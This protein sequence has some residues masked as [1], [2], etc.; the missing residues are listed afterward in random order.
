MT[1]RLNKQDLAATLVSTGSF[2]TKKAA[3]IAIEAVTDAIRGIVVAGNA[4]AIPDFGKFEAYTRE[5][6]KVKPKFIP[7]GSFKADMVGA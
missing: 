1:T 5:N 4:V 2:E 6:G 7:F 3:L